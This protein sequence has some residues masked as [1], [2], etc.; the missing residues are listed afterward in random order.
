MYA[1]RRGRVKRIGRATDLVMTLYPFEP[2]LYAQHGV[3]AE[4]VGHPL[5]DEIEPVD[6]TAAARAQLG[7]AT[8]RLVDCVAAGQP[9]CRSF[10]RM[11]NCFMQTAEIVAKTL[12]SATLAG[13]V[14]GAVRR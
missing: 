6:H 1:W 9:R 13:A 12:G 5:A 2:P 11:P 8:D 4:F 3:R 14:P 10:A 7:I